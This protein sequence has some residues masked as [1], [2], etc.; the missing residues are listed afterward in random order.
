[1]QIIQ[2]LLLLNVSRQMEAVKFGIKKKKFL[3]KSAKI[4]LHQATF[5]FK[6]E[7]LLT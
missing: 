4:L 3:E 6:R 2:I 7:F 1:M 5:P